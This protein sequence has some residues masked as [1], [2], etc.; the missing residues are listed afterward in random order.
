MSKA[1]TARLA[2]ELAECARRPLQRR[3]RHPG[4]AG[5]RDRCRAW[6]GPGF[7]ANNYLGLSNETSLVAAAKDSLDRFGFGMRLGPLHLR[8]AERAQ[9]A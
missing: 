2:D 8:Y 9:G 4:T 6:R 5:F 1:I 3:T 7:C